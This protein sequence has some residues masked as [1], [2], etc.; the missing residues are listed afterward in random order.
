M[1][2]YCLLLVCQFEREGTVEGTLRGRR[3]ECGVL[4]VSL[5]RELKRV[6][7]ENASLAP[8]ALRYEMRPRD[9]E[10]KV[11]EGDLH[12]IALQRAPKCSKRKAERLLCEN[13]GL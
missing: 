7:K 10:K 13:K 1:I 2:R 12:G 5:D 4:T 3:D 11:E 6:H 9:L 8:S